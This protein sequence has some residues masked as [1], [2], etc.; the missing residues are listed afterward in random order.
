VLNVIC[1][2]R[3]DPVAVTLFNQSYPLPNRSGL[4]NSF[5]TQQA[6][7]GVNGAA[8][9]SSISGSNGIGSQLYWRQ[10]ISTASA[11]LTK[12]VGSHLL[13]M[14]GMTSF[15]QW[16]SDPANG[17]VT[18]TFD[19][20]A[21]SQSSGVGGSAVAAALLGIPQTVA[22][23]Y[24]GGSRARLNPYG[25]FIDDTYQ[26]TKN[27]TLTL[28]LR[29]DQPR[30]SST[31]STNTHSTLPSRRVQ[32]SGRH[33]PRNFHT[34]SGSSGSTTVRQ[35]RRRT[36]RCRTC[37]GRT[38]PILPRPAIRTVQACPR[39]R[40]SAARRPGCCISHPTT[41]RWSRS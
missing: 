14:G 10:N 13:K 27:L 34:C 19:P 2:D 23:N 37:C 3:L 28:G 16:N 35:R 25:F 30:H 18:L 22:T 38:G 4:V 40:R 15:V 9:V 21:T 7:G 39:G 36:R 17:P 32:D 26:A 41:Q 12:I 20:I 33:M 6:I 29:W 11:S 31:T 8:G 5:V 1:P 24:I